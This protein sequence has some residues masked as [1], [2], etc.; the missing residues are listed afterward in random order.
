MANYVAKLIGESDDEHAVTKHFAN[1]GDAINWAQGDGLLEF[2]QAA[3]CEISIDGKVVWAKSH[4]KNPDLAV[5]ESR[6]F[7]ARFGLPASSARAR[8]K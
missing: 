7:L 4:L 6:Q 2:N 8:F 3:R 5:R 1:K